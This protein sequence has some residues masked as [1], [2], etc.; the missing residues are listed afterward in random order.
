MVL[1][2]VYVSKIVLVNCQRIIYKTN[3]TGY[4]MKFDSDLTGDKPLFHEVNGV[5]SSILL[6]SQAFTG[7]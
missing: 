2:K 6:I 4:R 3:E 5:E 1:H 7:L